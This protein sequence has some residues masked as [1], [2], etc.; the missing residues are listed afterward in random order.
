MKLC[1]LV[2]IKT[3]KD[4]I[5]RVSLSINESGFAYQ[6]L[7]TPSSRLI[8]CIR[9]FFENYQ[10]GYPLPPLEWGSV[11][12]FTEKVLKVLQTIPF[13]KTLTY[14]EVARQLGQ[15][16][17]ARAVGGACRSNPFPLFLPCHRVVGSSS[18]GG[19]SGG[20]DLKK[21]LLNFEISKS[22]L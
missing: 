20:I 4:R 7:G 8:L 16:K 13:G 12:P 1:I 5:K 22:L 10:N 3:D 6:I 11:T 17:A 9:N 19:F 18:I 14:G 2:S 21:I 15:P